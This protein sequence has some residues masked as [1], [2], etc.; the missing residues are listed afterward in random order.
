MRKRLLLQRLVLELGGLQLLVL[1]R[2]RCLLELLSG[3]SGGC[4]SSRVGMVL[5]RHGAW[6]GILGGGHYAKR[7]SSSDERARR[8]SDVLD[9]T[10]KNREKWFVGT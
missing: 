3:G 2:R 1:L 10:E 9:N 5:G 7:S 4:S 6:S 8:T